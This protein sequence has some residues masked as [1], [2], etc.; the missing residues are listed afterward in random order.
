MQTSISSTSV[1]GFD[2][3]SQKYDSFVMKINKRIATF[4][5]KYHN[6]DNRPISRSQVLRIKRV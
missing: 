2:P 4:I 6:F 1:L 5:L 3:C